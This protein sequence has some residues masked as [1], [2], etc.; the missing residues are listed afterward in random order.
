MVA[1]YGIY[2][3]GSMGAEAIQARLRSFD[4]EG[5]AAAPGRDRR[6]RYRPAQD[7]RHQAPQGRQRLPHDRH[8]PES[9]VLD[10]I[11]VIPPDL[12]PMVQLDGWSLRHQ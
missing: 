3:K 10:N 11:P 5:E 8:A 7:P 12:R 6:E 2:F 1:D 4:L 9:M